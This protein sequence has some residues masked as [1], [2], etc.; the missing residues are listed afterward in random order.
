MLLAGAGTVGDN[1]RLTEL[2]RDDGNDWIELLPVDA[3]ASD[4]VSARI[5]LADNAPVMLELTDGLG[6]LTRIEFVDVEI[7]PGLDASEFEFE[8]PRGVLVVGAD[9]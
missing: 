6:D 8:P 4:F 1:Y 9:D 7:N 2:S 3:A 5:G